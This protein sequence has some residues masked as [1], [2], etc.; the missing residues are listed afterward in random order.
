MDAPHQFV[1]VEAGGTQTTLQKPASGKPSIP[2][3]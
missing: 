1:E 3:H 2:F